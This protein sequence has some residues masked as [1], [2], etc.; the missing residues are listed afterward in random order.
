MA[1]NL[2]ENPVPW[3]NGAKCAV[4]ITFDIDTDS[5]LHLHYPDKAE[6]MV[7]AFSYLQYDEVAIPR[8][9]KM[10]RHFDIKQTF[11]YPAWCMERYPHLVDAILEDGHEIAAHGYLHENPN[12][13]PRE[14]E[15]YWLDKQ[16][17]VIE[18]MTGQ[19]PRGWRA[20]LYNASRWSMDMLAERGLIYDASLMGD[21]IPYILSTS[22]GSVITLPTQWAMDDWPH[23]AHNAEFEY[24]MMIKAPDDAMKVFH[25]E[26]EAMHKHGG[27][28]ITVWHPFVSGRLARLDRVVSWIEQMLDYG[29]VWFATMEDIA[30]HVQTCVDDGSWTPRIDK[31]PYY[32][33]RIPE[34]EEENAEASAG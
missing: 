22:H 17:D 20:P 30:R 12:D 14:R 15:A 19:K 4:A 29:G 9:L 34:W 24:V 2:I 25:A 18:R 31:L 13:M 32:T 28:L 5:M 33:G 23:Y 16:I 1:L 11:F 26:F 7:A 3:P 27:M 10:Y 21:D 6:D 8:I